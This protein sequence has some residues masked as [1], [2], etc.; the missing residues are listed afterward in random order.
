[1]GGICLGNGVTKG[2][3]GV[4]PPVSKWVDSEVFEESWE[5]NN[6][7][8][9]IRKQTTHRPLSNRLQSGHNLIVYDKIGSWEGQRV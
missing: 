2:Y 3:G 1:M 6:E 9:E 4:E 5:S 8:K 7:D